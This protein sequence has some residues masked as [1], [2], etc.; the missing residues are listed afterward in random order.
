MI[1]GPA[2][3]PVEPDDLPEHYPWPQRDGA[4]WVRAM[5]VCTLD[6]AAAGADG[7]SGSVSGEADGAV[8]S[9]VRRLADAVLVGGGT[10]AAEGYGP[11]LASDRDAARR[12]AD[13]QAP[14]PVLAVVSGSLDLPLADDRFTTSTV[15]PLVFT[16]AD[17]DPDRLAALR[18]RCEV[19][20]ADGDH[21]D[22]G[23]VIDCLV[24]RGLWRIV[25]EGGPSLLGQVAEAGRL[26]EAD[27]TFSPMLV[28]TASTPATAML[29]DPR[30]FALHHVLS[31]DDFLMSRYVRRDGP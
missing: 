3:G 13:G 15:P 5:M 29:P 30:S 28:G 16:T 8:F 25:C 9:A 17:P 6:G 26:D 21:V 7:L 18:E 23:W 11:M 31:A 27:L 14:A 22:V 10:L 2:R 4:A 19:V 12:E 24:A 20:Q 1:F